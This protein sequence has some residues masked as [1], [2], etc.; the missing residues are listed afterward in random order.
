MLVVADRP[1]SITIETRSAGFAIAAADRGK[2]LRLSGL[3]ADITITLPGAASLGDGFWCEIENRDP[4]YWARLDAGVGATLDGTR[5]Y[6]HM[7]SERRKL[8]VVGGAWE[9]DVLRPFDWTLRIG[10]TF[11]M[12][13]GYRRL[14]GLLIATGGTGSRVDS[15]ID[16]N[17]TASGG[18]G[19]AATPIDTAAPAVGTLCD[20]TIGA[21]IAG[22]TGFGIGSTGNASSFSVTGGVS[23]TAYPGAGGYASLNGNCCGGGGGGALSAGSNSGAAAIGGSPGSGN[24]ISPAGQGLGGASGGIATALT[25]LSDAAYGGAS[26]CGF[27]GGVPH[28]S[29]NT[30]MGGPSGGNANATAAAVG[31]TC[32]QRPGVVGGASSHNASAGNG[33]GAGAGG[34][35]CTSTNPTDTAGGVEAGEIQLR[36]EI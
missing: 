25:L 19:G 10:W 12:P 16:T 6:D 17:R 27:V 9:S 15:A 23:I 11:L 28:P 20:W 32:Q 24:A 29:G 4:D 14:A 33:V 30:T 36:G 35:G 31:G 34:G 13:A 5:K 22:R 26:S 18:G 8:F 3:S 1:D 21:A 2:L 7:K